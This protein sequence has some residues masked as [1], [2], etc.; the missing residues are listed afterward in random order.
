VS[1]SYAN[2][3][4]GSL[5][6]RTSPFLKARAQRERAQGESPSKRYQ[7]LIAIRKRAS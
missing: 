1:N 6:E 7:R 2:R 4:R 5:D 3:N